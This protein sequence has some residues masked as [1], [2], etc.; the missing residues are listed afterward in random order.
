MDDAL[1]GIRAFQDKVSEQLVATTKTI[2]DNRQEA[3]DQLSENTSA[4]NQKL[5]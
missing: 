3:V 5:E 1:V 4:F 2:Q